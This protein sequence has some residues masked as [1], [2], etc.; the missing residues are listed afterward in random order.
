MW[1]N[2]VNGLVK[3]VPRQRIVGGSNTGKCQK[4]ISQWQAP[5]L[6]RDHETGS[7]QPM[8]NFAS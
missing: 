1:A 7:S 8:F 3:L 2:I 5:I 6:G 4:C